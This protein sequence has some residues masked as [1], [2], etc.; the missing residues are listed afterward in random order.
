[1][2]IDGDM[3]DVA[4]YAQHRHGEKRNWEDVEKLPDSPDAPVAYVAR[5]SHATYFEAGY[6][7]TEAWYDIADGKRKAP[8]LALEIVEY[9]THPWMRWPGRWGDTTPR[10]RGDD[11][12]QSAPDRARH[13]EALARSRQAA[14]QRQAVGPAHG[15]ARPRREADPRPRRPAADRVRLQQRVRSRRARSSSPSTPRN[16][17]GVPP[18][19]HTFEEVAQTPAGTIRTDIPLH[20]RAQLRPVRVAPSPATL[21]SRRRRSS[22]RSRLSDVEKDQPFGQEVA[23]AVGKLFAKIRGDR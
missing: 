8:K 2:G 3:P 17:K 18:I 10:D 7:Q 16:E 13:E 21:P 23:Q 5:G 6:H 20:P 12:D 4:V 15:A 1:M 14:R 19:T 9:A 22:P 11:L